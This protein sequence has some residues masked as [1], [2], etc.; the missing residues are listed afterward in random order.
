ML[1]P[2][3]F[4]DQLSIPLSCWPIELQQAFEKEGIKLDLGPNERTDESWGFIENKGNY[5]NLIT[6]RSAT[7]EDFELIKRI[8]FEI[9]LK[10]E[11]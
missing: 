4:S 2:S 3:C 8:S 7:I 11:G 5:Y 6:Y 9:A 10:K 1:I